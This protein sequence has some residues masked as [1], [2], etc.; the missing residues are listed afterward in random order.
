MP[1]RVHPDRE[2]LTVEEG[3][4]LYSERSG[5]KLLSASL[6]STELLS[7]RA[8]RPITLTSIQYLT[9]LITP[10]LPVTQTHLT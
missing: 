6:H 9:I 4:K 1:H 7:V 5:F 2:R 10:N 8:N 3:H